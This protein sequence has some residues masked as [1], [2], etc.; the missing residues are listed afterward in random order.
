MPASHE[1]L[2]VDR[3]DFCTA[4]VFRFGE[5][6]TDAHRCYSLERDLSLS[7]ATGF[8]VRTHCGEPSIC[9]TSGRSKIAKLPTLIGYLTLG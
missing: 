4:R 3:N 8:W 7:F 2:A 1:L 5:D 9:R 6:P